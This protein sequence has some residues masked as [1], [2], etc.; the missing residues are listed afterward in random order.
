MESY[1]QRASAGPPAEVYVQMPKNFKE[2]PRARK[3]P[4]AVEYPL[5]FPKVS[6]GFGDAIKAQCVQCNAIFSMINLGMITSL[7]KCGACRVATG[8]CVYSNCAKCGKKHQKSAKYCGD[9]SFCHECRAEDKRG[10]KVKSH[11][12]KCNFKKDTYKDE[13]IELKCL[14]FKFLKFIPPEHLQEVKD[15]IKK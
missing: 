13:L 5:V 11:G 3:N 4:R 9:K 6:R 12:D 1:A 8:E 14:L 10:R 7:P 15:A 2:D